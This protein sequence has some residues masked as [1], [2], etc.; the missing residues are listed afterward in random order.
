MQSNQEQKYTLS[1]DPYLP[2]NQLSQTHENLESDAPKG[3]QIDPHE[4]KTL[5]VS[6]AKF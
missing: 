4:A 1:S 2:A 6:L 3:P 5:L